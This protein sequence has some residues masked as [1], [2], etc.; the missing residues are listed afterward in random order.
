MWNLHLFELE[1]FTSVYLN[2][3]VGER[4]QQQLKLWCSCCKALPVN[5]KAV[6]IELNTQGYTGQH[7]DTRWY[8]EQ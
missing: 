5:W 4:E 3:R 6:H 7:A 1:A 2:L 8:N